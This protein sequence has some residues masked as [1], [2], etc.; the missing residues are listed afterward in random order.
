MAITV[1]AIYENGV[2]NP[3]EPLPFKEHKRVSITVEPARI[4]IW[5]KIIA[6]TADAPEE[7]LAKLPVD[8]ASQH[9]HYIYG[10]PKRPE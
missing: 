9:D 3:S 1:D 10:T 4:P 5:E 8:G 7:E 2:L 6:L